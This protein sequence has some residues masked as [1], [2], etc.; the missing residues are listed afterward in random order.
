MVMEMKDVTGGDEQQHNEECVPNY[1]H[2][3]TK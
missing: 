1:K 3:Y 2:T